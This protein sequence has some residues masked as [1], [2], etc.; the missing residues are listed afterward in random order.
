MAI[1]FLALVS[2][3][4]VLHADKS[5]AQ[6]LG[7]AKLGLFVHYAFGLTQAAP[8]RPPMEDV[9]AF[10]DA[11]D[12]NGIAQ[13]AKAMG[14][15]YVVFTSFH[16][17]NTVLFP[18]RVWGAIFPN[19]VTHRDVIAALADVLNREHIWL[20]LYV[21]PDTRHDFSEAMLQKLI[22][23]GYCSASFRRA[24]LN[25]GMPRDPRWN[26]L[27]YRLLDETCRRYGKE[28]AGYYEDDGGAG[29]N[30][31]KVQSIM[32][33]YTPGA[34]IWV[35]GNVSDPP[36]TLVGG[37]NWELFDHNPV[38]H[39]YNTSS[40][41]VNIVI[42]KTWWASDREPTPGELE[43]MGPVPKTWMAEK[44]E[45]EYTPASMYRFLI[46]SIATQGEHNGG[47]VYAT[48]P[49]SDNQ[50][51][52]GVPAGLTA[53]GKLVKTNGKAI[54]DTV[55]SRAYVSGEPA[56][57]KPSWGVAVDSLNGRAVYLHVLMPPSGRSLQISKPANGVT[58]SGATL[59]NGEA[60]EMRS[61]PSGYRLTLPA[62]ATWDEVDTVIAL[63]VK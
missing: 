10:A 1:I 43:A 61:N 52:T 7:E 20:V 54:Y 44:G 41:E 33:H 26:R 57:Q 2:S 22:R 34:A 62:G 42:A 56:S 58:F 28:I 48:S 15:Q 29:S 50:W 46:C 25:G 19:N 32:E 12:V 38:P 36:A 60:L 31:V 47:V 39:L 30:G 11:L 24:I 27:Y 45:L 14:A 16:W 35:N 23:A 55:P 9:N 3:P 59:L 21:N 40:R 4:A 13:M 51:E 8:G 37:D 63:G 18:S 17:R 49:F 5:P 6:E 53:L